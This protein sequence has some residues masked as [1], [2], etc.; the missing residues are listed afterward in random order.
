MNTRQDN[1]LLVKDQAIVMEVLYQ[2]VLIMMLGYISL[3]LYFSH[4]EDKRH[5]EFNKRWNEKK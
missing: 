5:K 3:H 1:Y 4:R 2:I